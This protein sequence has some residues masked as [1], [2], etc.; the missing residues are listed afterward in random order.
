MEILTPG[1]Y[2]MPADEYHADPCP[3]P[4]LSASVAHLL[5]TQSALHAW[6]AHPKLNPEWERDDSTAAQEAGTAL[7]ALII[8]GRD[9]IDACYFPDWRKKEAQVARD[10]SRLL[11]RIPVLAE[12]AEQLRRCAEV[13]HASLERHEAPAL[14]AQPGQA[15]AVMVWQ[16]DTPW[17]QIWCRSR[18]DW[19]GEDWLD[20]LK[21]TAGSAHPD[22]WTKKVSP[23]G[24]A[25]Q[26]AFYLR[27]ARALGR[28][29]RGF[30]F[31]VVEQDPPFGMIVVQLGAD[32]MELAEASAARAIEAWAWS[33]REGQWPGYPTRTIEASAPGWELEQYE[34]RKRAQ[35]QSYMASSPRVVRSGAPFA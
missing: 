6:T 24:Y 25:L 7:H 31:V 12:K 21:T 13:V 32:L 22:A 15:E 4:S 20:D 19:L 9:L 18:V 35:P 26:A 8:E 17:G 3:S 1:V 14:F 29:P 28:R 33:L 11:G 27:G 30:R 10:D 2:A 16:E 34:Q 23:E 5:E